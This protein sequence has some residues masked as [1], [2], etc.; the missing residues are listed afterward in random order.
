MKEFKGRKEKAKLLDVGDINGENEKLIR[1]SLISCVCFINGFFSPELPQRSVKCKPEFLDTQMTTTMNS[2][3]VAPDNPV[4]LTG[5]EGPEKLLEI[6]FSTNSK[7][8]LRAVEPTIWH[9]MLKIV[10]CQVLSTIHNE[11]ADAYLLS[12]SS[13]F[14]YANR[15]I[16]KTC[17]TTTLLNSVPR[18]LQIAE[19]YCK[20]TKVDAIF[21]SRK[22]FLFPNLQEFP[23]GSWGDEVIYNLIVGV[24]FGWHFPQ[25][26]I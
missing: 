10:Q 17:G 3:T 25:V 4:S 19:E 5:F 1:S 26:S 6:W 2:I 21:Y 11:H 24:L 18:I 12:E 13:M 8:G 7:T 9:D 16:L 23:H 14:V 22:A 20:F 15:L